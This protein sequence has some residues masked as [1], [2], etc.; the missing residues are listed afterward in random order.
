[1]SSS[2]MSVRPK[3]PPFWA[4]AGAPTA[5][6]NMAPGASDVRERRFKIAMR[7]GTVCLNYS[8]SGAQSFVTF[9]GPQASGVNNLQPLATYQALSATP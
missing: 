1:M 8:T 4:V 2:D 7:C 6:R 3:M 9:S 5:A